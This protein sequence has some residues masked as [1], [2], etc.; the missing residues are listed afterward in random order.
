[1]DHLK[2]VD[3]NVNYEWAQE[4]VAVTEPG[5]SL[6]NSQP[7]ANAADP[8]RCASGQQDTCLLSV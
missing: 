1:M 4:W 3:I 6:R 2:R 7:G 8:Q 5:G